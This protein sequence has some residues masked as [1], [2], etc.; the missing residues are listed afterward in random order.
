MA[1]MK[2]FYQGIEL[3]GSKLYIE[4]NP[5]LQAAGIDFHFFRRKRRQIKFLYN[6]IFHVLNTTDTC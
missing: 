5:E 2:L 1:E 6:N 3:Y 4:Y